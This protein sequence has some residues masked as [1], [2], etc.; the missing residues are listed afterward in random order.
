MK[1]L[2]TTAS[3]MTLAVALL[4]SC[5]GGNGS[6]PDL[7]TNGTIVISGATST[8]SAFKPGYKATQSML[9]GAGSTTL[10]SSVTI[11]SVKINATRF[12]LARN[13]DCSNPVLIE[14]KTATAAYQDL[15]L[16]PTLFSGSIAPGTYNCMIIQSSDLLKFTTGAGS[17][18]TPGG[19]C[20]AGVE[21]TF[22]I[23]KTEVPAENW[24]NIVT[25]QTTTGSGTY[26]SPD[27]QSVTLFATTG[28]VGDIQTAYPQV[29]NM[30]ALPLLNP[31]VIT[32][33]STA[34]AAFVID[35]SGRVSVMDD[36]INTYCWLEGATFEF[37][38]Q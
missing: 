7:S 21:N 16:K 30:Q 24:Y 22:D 32:A 13:A 25:G 3:I 15:L 27:E 6:T 33:G 12:Y 20:Q 1:T 11:T 2:I 28:T 18:T 29:I 10:Y 37:V 4:L 19:A 17:E 5:G 31:I 23:Y 14:D 34:K 26:G 8:T 9:F 35:P 36:G 38:L